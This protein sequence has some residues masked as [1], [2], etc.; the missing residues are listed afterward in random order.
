MQF[1]IGVIIIN[2]TKYSNNYDYNKA[3]YLMSEFDFLIMVFMIKEDQSLSSPIASIFFEYYDDQS[4]LKS[5][6]LQLDAHIQ[7]IV[8]NNKEH[9]NFW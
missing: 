5:K 1:M 2:E 9:I 4:Q 3:V 7:C 6:L 8:S